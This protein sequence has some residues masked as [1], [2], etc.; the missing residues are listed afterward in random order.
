M[1]KIYSFCHLLINPT[2]INGSDKKV[3]NFEGK[4]HSTIL[5]NGCNT[6]FY[7]KSTKNIYVLTKVSNQTKKLEVSKFL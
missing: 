4:L 6:K 2:D 3:S 1:T 7:T 5:W